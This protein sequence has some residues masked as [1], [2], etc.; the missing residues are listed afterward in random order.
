VYE[1]QLDVTEFVAFN[2]GE[3]FLHRDFLALPGMLHLPCLIVVRVFGMF[4]P[5]S[6]ADSIP[7][8]NSVGLRFLWTTLLSPIQWY[9][10][11]RGLEWSWRRIRTR[12]TNKHS[13]ATSPNPL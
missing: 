9:S 3:L 7:G 10:I 5:F 11:A 2:H 1:P 13:G 8:F 6:I 12:K 4:V